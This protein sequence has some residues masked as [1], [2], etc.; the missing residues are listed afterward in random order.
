MIDDYNLTLL[1]GGYYKC[2]PSWSKKSTGIDQCYK[3]YFPVSGSA[4]LE[5][6][7]GTFELKEGRIYFSSGFHL[8]RQVCS[9]RMNV[10]W[11]HFVPESIYLRYL[12]DQLPPVCS[13]I[14]QKSGWSERSYEEICRI[15]EAPYNEENRLRID[16]SPVVECRIHGLLLNLISRLLEK[17]NGTAVPGFHPGY[18]RIK[19]ALAFINSN[20]IENPS[21]KIISAKAGMAPNYFHRKFKELFGLTPFNYMLAQRMNRARHLL[22]SSTLSI[23]EI[24]ET[25]GYES[26]LYFSR[27]FRSQMS[28]TPSEYRAV[29]MWSA[30]RGTVRL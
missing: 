19:P 22:T 10:Y 14:L 29:N 23:K 24:A 18:Y 12:L 28:L 7:T 30:A 4:T 21:L 9:V 1:S 3:V 6:D 26:P 13:W 17:L 27:V 8:I 15:F 16:S 25:V 20:C 5:M 11:L 2:D